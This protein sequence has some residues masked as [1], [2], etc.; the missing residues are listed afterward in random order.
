MYAHCVMG[1]LPLPFFWLLAAKSGAGKAVTEMKA[2]WRNVIKSPMGCQLES[3][4][5]N[6]LTCCLDWALTAARFTPVESTS[7][8]C[9]MLW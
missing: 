9:S 3:R 8:L 7:A 1:T 6:R 5:V 4:R 2:N